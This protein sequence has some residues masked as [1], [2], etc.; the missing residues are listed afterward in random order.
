MLKKVSLKFISL[1]Q[2][3]ISPLFRER[4]RFYPSCS[5]YT[6]RAIEK[7]GLFRGFLRGAFRILKCHPYNRG[8][9]DIP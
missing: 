9:V 3:F 7:Y 1:Y 6:Y 8:G 4:C 5:E 2:I